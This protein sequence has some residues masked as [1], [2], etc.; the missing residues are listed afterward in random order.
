[1]SLGPGYDG[2]VFGVESVRDLE[3][4]GKRELV[5]R[6]RYDVIERLYRYKPPLLTL[7]QRD[8]AVRLQVDDQLSRTPVMAR[9]GTMGVS[10]ADASFGLSEGVLEAC[11]IVRE[12]KGYLEKRHA[13]IN[14]GVLWTCNLWAVVERVVVWN[15]NL[16]QTS[17]T[18]RVQRGHV[19][20]ALRIGLNHLIDFYDHKG[21]T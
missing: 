6:I 2:D 11:K 15:C 4:K 3:G 19:L 9:V 13:I 14:R 7:E 17:T 10:H 8:A 1:M 16:T 12:A 18:F 20:P 21:L 5:R